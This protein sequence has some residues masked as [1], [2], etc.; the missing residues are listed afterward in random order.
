MA[1][2][3]QYGENSSDALIAALKTEHPD[4]RQAAALALGKLRLRRAVAPLIEQ[5]LDEQDDTWSE[6]ARALGEYGLS[7]LRK[8]T[9]SLKGTKGPDQRFVIALAHLANHGCL[10]QVQKL[11]EESSLRIASAARKAIAQRPRIEWEDQALREQRP[12]SGE[13]DAMK[14]SRAFYAETNAINDA[15]QS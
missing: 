6:I 4:V 2:L 10:Q 3:L 5:M 9:R 12:L 8:V 13:S 11:K 14:L 1:Y 7:A 15:D